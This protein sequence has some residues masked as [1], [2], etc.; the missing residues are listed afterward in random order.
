MVQVVCDDYP[1][2]YELLPP[3]DRSENMFRYSTLSLALLLL[4][5][6]SD[7]HAQYS[8]GNSRSMYNATRNFL[9]N[10]P[11]VSPY[12]QLGTNQGT[13]ALPNYHTLV[14][15]QIEQQQEQIAQQRQSAQLQQQ[16][17]QIQDQYR[18]QQSQQASQMIT[19]RMGWSTRGLPRF[20]STLNYY[21][22]FYRIPR[23]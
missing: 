2:E 6:A 13:A 10:R 22:G 14:R 7:A 23:R 17:S 8:S 21:P 9:Y 18:Q 11:T 4:A 12:V 19:G 15:P 3:N 1:V 5:M 16:V 20:G